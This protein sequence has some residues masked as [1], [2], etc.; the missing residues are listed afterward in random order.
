[1]TKQF[2]ELQRKLNVNK[3]QINRGPGK[4]RSTQPA[5]RGYITLERNLN[6]VL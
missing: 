4:Q 6:D 5:S 1:M 3:L 2:P